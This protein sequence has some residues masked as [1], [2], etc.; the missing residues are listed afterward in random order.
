MRITIRR[1]RCCCVVIS[2][3]PK[4]AMC[5]MRLAGTNMFSEQERATLQH[6]KDWGFTDAFRL[7]KAGGKFTWWDYRGSFRRN[8][9]CASITSGSPSR[10]S[11]E[12]RTW[13]DMD[14]RDMGKTIRPR[15]GACGNS[16]RR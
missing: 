3:L 1:R 9:D 10:S 11:R 4:S 7:H 12:A 13:I 14:P 2:T 6:I 16:V 5:T 8:S 15:A